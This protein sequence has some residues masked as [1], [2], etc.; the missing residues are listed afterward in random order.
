MYECKCRM[1]VSVRFN[2]ILD[3]CDEYVVFL[4]YNRKII[5]MKG[6]F[7]ITKNNTI[8]LDHKLAKLHKLKWK[9]LYHIPNYIEPKYNQ[10]CIDEL[11]Y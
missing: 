5:L 7:S 9:L 1:N 6:D 4:I 3:S 8:T 11:R 10:V 2:K